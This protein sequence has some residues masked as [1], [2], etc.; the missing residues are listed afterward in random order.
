MFQTLKP[1]DEVEGTGMGLA[2]VRRLVEAHGGRIWIDRGTE[3]GTT[4][5]FTW[6]KVWAPQ[7]QA[8]SHA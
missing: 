5:R 7:R 3:S 6:P 4:I 2:L 8:R 1:R